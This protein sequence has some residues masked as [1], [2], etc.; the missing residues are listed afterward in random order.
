M[1]NKYDKYIFDLDG[2]LYRGNQIIPGAVEVINEIK[3][4]GKK[5]LFI[6]N[7]TTG[8]AKDY[9]LFMKSNGFNVDESELITAGGIIKNYLTKHHSRASFYMIGEERF[10][11]EMI[12]AGLKYSA[13]PAGINIIIVT[14]DRTI[15]KQKIE[16]AAQALQNGAL[17]FA[18]NIDRTCPVETGEIMDAGD[19]IEVLENMTGIKLAK[20][21]GKPSEFM[22]EAIRTNLG[23]DLNNCL[24]IGDRLETDIKMGNLL[25]VDTAH[26]STGVISSNGSGQISPTIKLRSVADLLNGIE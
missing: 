25:G 3:N 20:N 24:L 10:I 21:F 5:V 19:T 23:G 1:I 22:R 2:T 14:L 26:V 16:I 7:K 11:R 6:S 18:A 12:D 17:F 15:T 13:N 8:S 9:F 4:K